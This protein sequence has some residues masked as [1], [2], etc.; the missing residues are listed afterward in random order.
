MLNQDR[1]N[2]LN[3]ACADGGARDRFF[4]AYGLR[5]RAATGADRLGYF[6]TVITP[7]WRD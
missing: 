2:T 1:N 4:P 7:V 3:P 5:D 6:E